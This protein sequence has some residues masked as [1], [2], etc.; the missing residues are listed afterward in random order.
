MEAEPLFQ[1]YECQNAA[2]RLRFPSNLS[3]RQF[4]QCPVCG[5]P[6]IKSGDPFS[7]AKV[8]LP[9]AAKPGP[10]LRLL[11]DNLRS[12]FN[13]GSIFRSA[14]CTA[15]E[16][17]YCCGTTPTPQHP[18]F[19]KAGLNSEQTA[20]WSYHPNA[21]EVVK[22]AKTKRFKIAALELTAKATPLF[23]TGIDYAPDNQLLLVVGNE[24]SG[25]DPAILDA[26]DTVVYIPMLGTKN[27]L[28]VAIAAAIAL[29][30][31]RF[32]LRPQPSQEVT[33]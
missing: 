20:S 13:V 26:A 17:I 8:N 30:T 27:S 11:L 19:I 31:F 32:S 3:I 15:I 14:N 33:S 6:V 12:T 23:S 28:N 5:A 16:H 1:I 21:L 10:V 22:E 29:Y 4:E 2:C 18:K 25:V 7:N 24:V 9:Q